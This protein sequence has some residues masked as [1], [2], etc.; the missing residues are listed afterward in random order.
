V[1]EIGKRL[2]VG[3]LLDGTVRKAGDRL[4][5]TVELVDASDGFR[6]WSERY[7][8]ELQDIFAIQDDIAHRVVEAL[9][10]TLS[11]SERHSLRTRPTLHVEAYDYYL[12]GRNYFY[13][14]NRRGIEFARQLFAH[15]IEIDPRF[16]RAHAG[17]ADCSA[18]L[19]LYAGR[20]STNLER[21]LAASRH[22]VEFD[23]TLAEAHA[24][25]GVALSMN[26][27]SVEA[28][29]AFGRAIE[30]N[31]DLFEAR[32]FYARDLFVQGRLDEAAR[33]YEEASRVRPE[34]YQALLLVA[35]IYE[36]LGRSEQA[37]VARRRGIELAAEH[38]KLNPDD[39]RARYMGANG[40]VA[41]GEREQGLAWAAEALALEPDDPMLLFNVACVYSLAG[42]RA[43]ALD[44]LERA[45]Q[46]GLAQRGWLEHDSNLDTIRDEP[47]FRALMTRL[48]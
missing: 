4:R 10:L 2:Q 9:Q 43:R 14:Y 40:L 31:P 26:G 27:Q 45:V 35:Q 37:G 29:R 5:V 25:L 36:D 16:A 48:A 11:A 18:Y 1:R 21:A 8:R 28:E 15:A 44:C 3:A 20:D 39:A 34:D 32:Y 19:Y 38:L 7:D 24:S 33:Q 30:L 46:V 13:R 47:R 17:M 42:E 6:I 41:L 12:R 23:A 22:A